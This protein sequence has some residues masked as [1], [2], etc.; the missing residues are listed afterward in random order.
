VL[1]E[2]RRDE[3]AHLGSGRLPQEQAGG[4]RGT[5]EKVSEREQRVRVLVQE[6]RLLFGVACSPL[7]ASEWLFRAILDW[8]LVPGGCALP[9]RVLT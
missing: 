9:R 7:R 3:S 8:R 6:E 4:Q 5:R 1:L 2:R